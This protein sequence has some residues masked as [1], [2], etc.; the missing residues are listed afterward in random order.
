M[1]KLG[2]FILSSNQELF[3]NNTMVLKEYYHQVIDRNK[4]DIDLY[5]F[6]GDSDCITTY[7]DGDTI[8]CK[9]DDRN[10]YEKQKQLMMYLFIK[11]NYEFILIVNN[12]TLVNIE[13]IYNEMLLSNALKNDSWYCVN[14]AMN[15]LLNYVYFKY[16]NGNFKLLSY[17]LLKNVYLVYETAYEKL[18]PLYDSLVGDFNTNLWNGVP[19]D[20]VLGLC[21]TFLNI[22]EFCFTSYASVYDYLTTDGIGMNFDFKNLVALTFKMPGNFDER[23]KNETALLKDIIAKIEKAKPTV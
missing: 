13:M 9:C 18:K 1:K 23:L 22:E 4:F 12:S 11:K 6:I 3:R 5:S 10:V 19:E 15:N 17:N 2:I 16:P 7:E 20:M 14:I 21:N 8:H